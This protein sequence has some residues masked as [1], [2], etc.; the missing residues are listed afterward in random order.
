MDQNRL[1][2]VAALEEYID[3]NPAYFRIPGHRGVRGINPALARRFGAPVFDYDLSETPLTDD[4]H[5]PA[6]SIAEAQ[7]LAADAFGADQSFFLVNGTTCGVEAMVLAAAR[8]GDTILI[9]RGAHKSALMGTILSGARPVWLEQET[10]APW[11]LAAGPTPETVE[12]GLRAHPEAKAVLLVSPTYYGLCSDVAAIAEACHRRGVALLVDEAHGAHLN[13]SNELPPCALE[14]GA[15]ACAQSIHKAAGALTQSSMLHLRGSR[16]AGAC[17]RTALRLVQSTSPSYLLMASL[18]AARQELALRGAASA[19]TAL[20]HA[21]GAAVDLAALPGVQVLGREAI[22]QAGVAALDETRLTFS[23]F[24]RGLTGLELQ[25]LLFERGVDTEL[26][27]HRNVMAL[28]TGGNTARDVERLVDAM[29]EITSLPVKPLCEEAQ[30]LPPIPPQ[31]MTPRQA[32][33]AKSC[34]VPLAHALGRTAAEA[35]IPYPPGIPA[36]CPGET[37]TEAVLDYI[38]LCLRD[39]V[40]LHGPADETLRTLRVVEESNGV[41]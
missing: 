33:F 12:E 2:L 28:F 32:F 19:H 30:P 34:A 21:R 20:S 24:D 29:R 18:D 13:F 41:V 37:V 17:V 25:K 3:L 7:A 31:R 14:Q 4:L 15:D 40:S 26:A 35:L 38:D 23:S 10:L 9:S 16:L 11:R 22:G 36:L 1:P 6:G 39:H 27:D 5:Q 8:E